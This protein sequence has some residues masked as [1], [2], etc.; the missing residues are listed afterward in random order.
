MV[1]SA[2]ACGPKQG[3]NSLLFLE[4][5]RKAII[6]SQLLSAFFKAVL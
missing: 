3:M 4:A 2:K 5:E 6:I 1:Q